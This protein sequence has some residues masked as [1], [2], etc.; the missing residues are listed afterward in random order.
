MVAFGVSR[1]EPGYTEPNLGHY[2]G[3]PNPGRGL[4]LKL[5]GILFIWVHFG[6]LNSIQFV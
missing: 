4:H 3:N 1:L 6:K 2:Y 5:L